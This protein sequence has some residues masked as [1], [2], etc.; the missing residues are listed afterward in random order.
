LFYD[1]TDDV[2]FSFF[3]GG[4][5]EEEGTI[6]KGDD[7]IVELN[8]TLEDFYTRLEVPCRRDHILLMF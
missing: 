5:M 6:M 7:V 1:K 4:S 3:G 2:S 8:A